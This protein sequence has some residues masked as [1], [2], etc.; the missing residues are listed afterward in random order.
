MEGGEKPRD[1]PG[2]LEGK[3]VIKI[4]EIVEVIGVLPRYHPE[5]TALPAV[6]GGE[7]GQPVPENTVEFL[8]IGNGGISGL[9]HVHSFVD[10]IVPL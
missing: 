10:P 8:E 3:L 5:D 2:R 6:V 7:D 9:L 1:I 4:P